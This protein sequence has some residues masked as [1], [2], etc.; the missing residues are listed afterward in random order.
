MKRTI[1]TI[2]GVYALQLFVLAPLLWPHWS[3]SAAVAGLDALACVIVTWRPAGKWQSVIG[4]TYLLQ[5]GVHAG[6]VV[7]EINTG[8]SNMNHYF[9]GLSLL[10][11]LQLFLLGG[12]LCDDY[13]RGR[14]PDLRGGRAR[15]LAAHLES[16][17]R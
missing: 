4:L 16:L 10:G 12:W 17:D 7:A 9:W 6:R 14:S 3:W 1:F 11:L 13:R 2:A 8:A 5:I 15:P